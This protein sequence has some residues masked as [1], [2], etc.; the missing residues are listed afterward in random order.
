MQPF[1][2]TDW[3][4]SIETSS[5]LYHNHNSSFDSLY[6]GVQGAARCHAGQ[7]QQRQSGELHERRVQNEERHVH[8]P[9]I[10]PGDDGGAAMV[11]QPR[12]ARLEVI[13]PQMT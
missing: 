10:C 5:V 6:G 3:L 11:G 4:V 12:V 7:D 9:E 2:A 1:S 13:T 8:Q